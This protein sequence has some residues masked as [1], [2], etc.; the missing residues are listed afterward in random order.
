MVLV[1]FLE[2]YQSQICQ[3][4]DRYEISHNLIT[5]FSWGQMEIGRIWV[6]VIEGALKEIIAN[7]EGSVVVRTVLEVDKDNLLV[8]TN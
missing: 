5:G 8:L 3:C 2:C 1:Y 4:I 7:I 6:I